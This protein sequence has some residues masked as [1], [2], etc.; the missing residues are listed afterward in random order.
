[1]ISVMITN[2]FTSCAYIIIN[3][4]GTL[5]SNASQWIGITDIAAYTTMHDAVSFSLV[6]SNVVQQIQ[7]IL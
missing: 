6:L 3:T 2:L 1:M 5:I 7:K 4:V